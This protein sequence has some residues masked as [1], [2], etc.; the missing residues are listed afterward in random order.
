MPTQLHETLL[1]LFRNRPT[2]APELLREAL[3]IELPPFTEARI[4]SPDLSEVQPTE[5]RADL[6]VLLLDG[7][8]VMGI[9]VEVQLTRDERKR[10][11]WPVY[12]SSLRARLEC[13][14][15]LLVVTAEDA[16]ARWAARPIGLG[17][18]SVLTPLVLGPS[19]VPIVTDEAQALA[20]P[21]LAVLSAMAH[22]KDDDVERAVRIAIAAQ[23]ASL[24]LDDEHATLY[25]DLI[26]LALSQAAREALQTMRPANYQ[27]QSEFAKH[28]FGQGFGQGVQEGNREGNREGR[29]ALVLRQ[30]TARFGVLPDAV[31]LQIAG[32]SISAL[33]E[34]GERLLSARSLEEA[35]G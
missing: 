33:D 15:L 5:Y 27:Y 2:L 21:E 24:S 35:L 12:I 20:D 31:R 17:G 30:L 1:L 28:Y 3:H 16:I 22:G 13:P 19:G 7:K 9:V 8:P 10:Y 11:V 29:A 34:I 25:W 4:D 6:V 14:V 26:L 32:A 18:D 23:A